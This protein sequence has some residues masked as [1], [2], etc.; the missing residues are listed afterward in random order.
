MHE[1][2][3]ADLTRLFHLTRPL[4]R[5]LA[6]E[7]F[8]TPPVPRG[9]TT[10]SFQDL[11][12]LRTAKALRDAAIPATKILRALDNIRT[13]RA[14]ALGASGKDLEIRD[15]AQAW[16]ATSGQYALPLAR[17]AATRVTSLPVAAPDADQTAPATKLADEHYARGFAL[18][19]RDA[20]AAR[21]AYL[22]ALRAHPDHLEARI[23]LGRL[24]HLSGELAAA[25]QV[26]RQAQTVSALLSFNLATL[27]EDLNRETE[28]AAAYR[29]V[30][31]Q[32]PYFHD[33][34]FN[35]S[36]LYE[37]ANLPREA[38]Q[39]LLAYRRHILQFG[40]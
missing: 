6:R 14:W 30:L 22:E 31:A 17:V 16:E 40:E 3:Q 34:H 4:L 1:Y 15:G 32:D 10:Y 7:G 18:E 5:S 19:E 25:E 9:R 35:L 33:A 20:A 13:T 28:A 2:S 29:K 8:I 39:H 26:Y 36:R 24:L 38:L 23:N 37:R 27:L 11:L 12:I 21:A